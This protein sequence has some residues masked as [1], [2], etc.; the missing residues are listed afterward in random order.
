MT[1][2]MKNSLVATIAAL[3][4]LSGSVSAQQIYAVTYR[5]AIDLALKNVIE[6][7]NLNI[8]YKMQEA[9]NKEI[10]GQAYPQLNGSVSGSHYFSIPVTTIPDFIS[11]AVYGVLNKEGVKD[12]SGNVI[13]IPDPSS[14]Q[15][16]PARF[17]V[18]WAASVGFTLQ[19]MLF[20]S[21]VF[22][23][24]KARSTALEYAQQNIRVSED[25]VKQNV[26]TAYYAV[27]IAQKQLVLTNE[28]KVRIDKL[29]HDNQI[30]Y[31]NGFAEKLD[32]DRIQVSLNNIESAIAQLDNV[33]KLGYAN[34]KQNMG[35]NQ[36]DS[37]ILKDSMDIAL[38]KSDILDEGSFR[39]EDRNEILLLSK[40]QRLLELDLQRYKLAYVPTFSA[41]WN[42][43]ESAQR[44]DFD[45]IRSGA[46]YPWFQTSQV[47]VNLN[48]PIFDGFQKSNRVKR[49]QFNLEKM[50]NT[51]DQTKLSIDLQQVA[52]RGSLKANLLAFDIQTKNLTLAESVYNTTKKKFEQGVG[53]SF[54]VIQAEN[55]LQ[56]AQSNYFEALY[57]ATLARIDYLRALGRLK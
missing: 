55:D 47:G 17:G 18:P 28:S 2:K 3:L 52:T 8:D 15:Y 37:L 56:T 19:Q 34:L 48:I 35:L 39:Y 21:D 44:N 5:E 31:Q 20:Q 40:S 14:V 43:S 46:Q 7:K 29:S 50:H 11:P 30:M 36:K 23:G 27:V 22:V 38:L 9:Q 25:Q 51:I 13:P 16:F 12:G 33:L 24:L 26:L 4:V 1:T 45:F 57:K 49:A 54:E 53:S 6:L 10:T 42:F 41:F 32:I